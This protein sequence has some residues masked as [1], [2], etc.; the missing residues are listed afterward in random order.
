MPTEVITI[1]SFSLTDPDLAQIIKIEDVSFPTDPYQIEDFQWAYRRCS[2][3][4]I[5][6]E[7][8]DQVVGYM[9]TSPL[10]ARGHIYSLAVAP[11]YRRRGVAEALFSYTVDRLNER[12]IEKI[13]LEV[14]RT[15]EAGCAFW[16]QMG[17]IAV[18]TIPDFYADGAEALLMRKFIGA[19]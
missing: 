13:E 12:G 7:I 9:M 8:A 19:G 14:S 18:G 16:E 6:A 11:A 4:S 5:V 10:G 2:E 17:F 15:N 1:R 3:L